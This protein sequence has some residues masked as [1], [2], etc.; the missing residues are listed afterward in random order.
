MDVWSK[1]EEGQGIMELLIRNE[2]VTDG[3]IGRQTDGATDICTT[4]CPLFF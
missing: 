4:I 3:P 1:F 2:K